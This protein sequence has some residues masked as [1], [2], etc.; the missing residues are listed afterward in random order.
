MISPKTNQCFQTVAYLYG[1]ANV[2]P[3]LKRLSLTACLLLSLTT[4]I[5]PTEADAQQ[6]TKRSDPNTYYRAAHTMSGKT[7]ILPIGTTFE[8][9]MSTSISS[10]QSHA[11]QAFSII[12]SSP[13][14][15]N[16]TDV[17]IPAGSEVIGEVVEAIPSKAFPRKR[18]M[19]PSRGKLRIQLNQL[20]TPDGTSYPLVASLAGEVEDT[21]GG[22]RTGPTLGSSVAYVG[23]AA[24]FEAV[25]PG[26]NRYGGGRGGQQQR[27]PEYVR[28]REFMAHEIYGTGGDRNQGDDGNRIRSLVIRKYDYWIDEGS[29]L[30]VRT[31]APLKL[32][33]AA[34]GA[35]VPLGNVEDA[36]DES[37]PGRSMKNTA[38]DI[39]PIGGDS[40]FP[41]PSAGTPPAN[42]MQ[43]PVQGPAP[44]ANSGKSP[45]SD[46]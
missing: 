3:A 39:P 24:A 44:G 13:L 38:S 17:V 32:G 19:P 16:G 40:S 35:G 30:T 5:F 15:A 37:L 43:A 25:A 18:K 23:T 33:I 2:R 1:N 9:R 14:L 27:G 8:G 31:G 42:T 34:P 6:R 21:K 46:F 29:P 26:S 28:K 41:A 11:G 20:R 4:S 10:A 45:S 7:I 12:L 36:S 22:H